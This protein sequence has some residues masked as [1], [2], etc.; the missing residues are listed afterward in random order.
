MTV[1]YVG[2][3]KN[4]ASTSLSFQNFWVGVGHIWFLHVPFSGWTN[5]LVL[6]VKHSELILSIPF[7]GL[8]SQ[9]AFTEDL[10]LLRRIHCSGRACLCWQQWRFNFS[11]QKTLQR[12]QKLSDRKCPKKSLVT[13]RGLLPNLS[14]E[15]RPFC[16]PLVD[17]KQGTGNQWLFGIMHSWNTQKL[18]A[19]RYLEYLDAIWVRAC[20]AMP[21][22]L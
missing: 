12:W 1:S 13:T 16:L 19:A 9:R 3:W 8:V 15:A 21:M 14:Q 11:N 18:C 6:A 2:P 7:L 17:F 10:V 20:Q 22:T 5:S 4:H